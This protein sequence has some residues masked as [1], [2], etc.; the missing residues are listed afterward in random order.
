MSFEEDNSPFSNGVSGEADQFTD[1]PL[2]E[3]EE[4]NS[5][6]S[7]GSFHQPPES[8]AGVSGA[9][10]S[11]SGGSRGELIANEDESQ[12]QPS[13]AY[14]I[15]DPIPGDSHL[16]TPTIS[17]TE[18]SKS[19]ETHSHRNYVVY[20]I[21]ISSGA[22][23]KRRYSE[24]E[25]LRNCLVK[26]LPTKIIPPIPEKQSLKSSLTATTTS[27]LGIVSNGENGLHGESSLS[28][29]EYRKR[30]LGVF[31]NRC[32]QIKDISESPLFNSFLD[33]KT[34]FNEYL[35]S[36]VGSALTKTSIYRLSP[37]DPLSNLDN[38]L[39]L[40]LP[41]P[42]G[43]G[44]NGNV[45]TAVLSNV[46]LSKEDEQQNELFIQFEEKFNQYETVLSNVAR[47]N[48]K[49]IKHLKELSA[50]MTELGSQFNALS[51]T[52]DSNLIEY[53]G[54]AFDNNYVGL[55]NLAELINLEFLQR[56]VELKNFT[57]AAMDLIDYNK[58]K[59]VQLGSIERS[60]KS[61]QHEIIEIEAREAELR[62]IE[63][64]ADS[65]AG[66]NGA[67]SSAKQAQ[68]NSPISDTDLQNSLASAKNKSYLGKIPGFKKVTSVLQS[69]TENNI[70]ETR[71]REAHELRIRVYQ[72]QR[73][74]EL[75]SADD[76]RINREVIAELTSFHA[77]FKQQ[78]NDLVVHYSGF[79]HEF[80]SKNMEVWEDVE[81]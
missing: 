27:S 73:Q 69:M 41:N 32:L 38:Q 74:H 2:S 40:T 36:S 1:L 20:T 75:V 19:T 47:I 11:V 21:N 51:L 18:A 61:K 44:S 50:D 49:M 9:S 79:L 24:F 23:V 46:Y 42:H 48:K 33:P 60:L 81:Q 37:F 7:S 6:K 67:R 26:L 66:T 17:I 64:T 80:Y 34:N 45:G 8:N 77:W 29:V 54:R 30:M 72:L 16:A 52:Q 58:H 31:L 25:N 10:S 53:I 78:L 3:G 15:T 65:I 56:L 22:M 12:P 14:P 5:R 55:K 68:Q 43:V 28:F 35:G 76:P 39:Y 70:E 63:E 71:K 4:H 59:I 62:R 57:K 13:D